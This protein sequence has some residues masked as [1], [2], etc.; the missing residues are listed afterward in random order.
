MAATENIIFESPK[1]LT[2]EISN[3]DAVGAEAAVIKVNKS[4]YT[5]PNGAEPS[6]LTIMEARWDVLA[7][8]S[9]DV[10]WDHTTNDRFMFLTG[11]GSVDFTDQGGFHDPASAG[12]TGDIVFTTIVGSPY[13]VTLHIRKKD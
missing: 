6:K 3:D 5:G 7:G 1:W 13:S 8:G 10:E 9:I 4:D 11:E 12:G 2:I